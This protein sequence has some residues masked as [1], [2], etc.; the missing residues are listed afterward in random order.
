MLTVNQINKSYGITSVLKN[1]SFTINSG[2][3]CGLIGINGSGK[4]TLL[5]ILNG[6][7][8]ADSGTFRY[9]PS[10]LRVGYL[11]Q[12]ADFD[13]QD[14]IRTFLDRYCGNQEALALELE[15]LSASI[16]HQENNTALQTRF[17]E[18]LALMEISR[19]CVNRK[20]PVLAAFSL[21]LM[22]QDTPVSHLSGGQKT[23]LMLAGVLLTNPGLLL[24]DE[25][26]NHL[27][28]AMLNWLEKWIKAFKGAVMIV[29]HD[30]VFLDN[31]VNSILELDEH[32]HEM[33]AYNGNYSD[34]LTA[35]QEE[36][37]KQWQSY[38]DQQEEIQRLRMAAMEMRSK[39]KYRPG[40]KTDPS[41]TDGFSIGFFA[42]RTKEVIQKAKN[43]EKRVESL[44]TDERIDK[45]ARTWH[46]RIDFGEQP[47][48]GREVLQLSE[49][50]IGYNN[51]AL[52]Q[53][54]NLT[55]YYGERVALIGA[56]GSG[57]TTLLKTINGEIA[58]LHGQVRL[59]A[60]VQLGYMTQEQREL[61][62][63]LN[64]LES[65]QKSAAMNETEQRSFLSKFLFKGD[66]V[67]VPVEKL[68]FGERARLSLACLVA[69]G[70][71][72]LILDEPVN[73]LDIPSRTQFEQALSNFKGT[74][75]AVVHDR[76][77]INAFARS[78]WEVDGN[79]ISIR[80]I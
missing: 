72:F 39:A 12:G 69:A 23:R 25:P 7:V 36:Q 38:K 74:I 65:L 73:H 2:D 71:N 54:I 57:K 61:N 21:D 3:R 29:S 34:Y 68:S 59:G 1:I 44:L 49:L 80:E 79:T 77:F 14:T 70:C 40:G 47:R 67:F 45:P 33:K 8:K 62:P 52:L 75:L 78:I 19:D 24:L 63:K 41:K 58:P 18:I 37:E 5:R 13:N 9:S 10:D 15:N 43:I 53:E 11:P 17:D 46:M 26:T 31:T 28:I 48:S 30:R 35:K 6:Q 27:D 50:A 51:S 16:M 20:D 32:T 56:N 22:P 42:N 66:D 76:Y 4:S 55:L 64:A 60:N